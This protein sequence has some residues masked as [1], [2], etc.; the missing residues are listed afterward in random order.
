MWQNTD[1]EVADNLE[2]SAETD[3]Y[4]AAL[5]AALIKLQKKH[6]GIPSHIISIMTWIIFAI[7]SIIFFASKDEAPAWAK[8]VTETHIVDVFFCTSIT[9]LY[10]LHFLN[11]GIYLCDSFKKIFCCDCC[12]ECIVKYFGGKIVTNS[13]LRGFVIGTL[14]NLYAVMNTMH[15]VT[16]IFYFAA[17]A[18]ELSIGFVICY[19]DT[20]GKSIIFNNNLEDNMQSIISQIYSDI[21]TKMCKL[22]VKNYKTSDAAAACLQ[23][24]LGRVLDILFEEYR[25]FNSKSITNLTGFAEL[26]VDIQLKLFN[27]KNTCNC[28]DRC[29]FDLFSQHRK[30]F[31]KRLFCCLIALCQAAHRQNT[32]NRRIKDSAESLKENG[33]GWRLSMKN[34]KIYSELDGDE[35]ND[36]KPMLNMIDPFISVDGVKIHKKSHSRGSSINMSSTNTISSLAT[37]SPHQYIINMQ[38]RFSHANG[39]TNI[40]ERDSDIVVSQ[41]ATNSESDDD[42]GVV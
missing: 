18:Y 4:I 1:A 39:L 28:T 10:V 16:A 24:V 38:Q 37:P 6:G 15:L 31:A 20:R 27:N 29:P 42:D 7:A 14:F 41:T 13:A 8:A 26:N 21:L 17:V 9:V 30:Y 5:D 33:D 11:M 40:E 23:F 32:K 25:I 35:N 12:S 3:G 34:T 2:L 22:N 36:G 19:Y